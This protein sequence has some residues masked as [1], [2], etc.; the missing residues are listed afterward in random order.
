[1]KRLFIPLLLML[2]CAAVVSA[3]ERAAT[4]AAL[5]PQKSLIKRVMDYLEES[6]KK[7]IGRNLDFSLLGGPYYSSESKFGIGL[8]AAGAYSTAPEDTL[9]SPS[10]VSIFGK[11]TTMPNF[12]VG[13][14]GEHIWPR[15]RFRLNYEVSFSAIRSFYWGAG[16]EMQSNNDNKSSYRYLESHAESH[17]AVRV[18]S[19]LYIG[20]LA[21]FDYINASHLSRPEMWDGQALR[22]FNW[23]IGASLRF[24]PRDNLTA[25]NSG[26]YL[27]WDQT[28]DFGWMGNKYPFKVNE[29]TAS[30]YHS[31]W[32]GAV[33]A[34]QAHW[35]VTWGNTPW[36]ML[37]TIGGS[38][39]M[40]GY[41]EGRYRDK[42]EA[43][44]TVELRQKVWRRNGIVVWAGVASLFPR[45]TDINLH[46]LL[47]NFGIG[48]RWEFKKNVNV[49]VDYGIGRHESGIFFNINE[50][51]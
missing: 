11:V 45:L 47:P 12:E 19:N 1:M 15:N 23:G 51:F 16:Y 10:N 28:F 46:H 25:P 43:D 35:R 13:V 22:T 37:S 7:P 49:R 41:Y 27:R 17:F 5:L 18:G 29:L 40:R 31:L 33:F 38:S 9:T 24:D 50:A 48:Y 6:N 21:T 39:N 3:E 20:P 8:V 32:R 2:C 26:L 36:G 34:S 14:E 42:G 30:W 44:I 4:T